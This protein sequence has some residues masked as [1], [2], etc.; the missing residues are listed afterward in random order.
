MDLCLMLPI[1]LGVGCLRFFVGIGFGLV[2][3]VDYEFGVLGLC[4]PI[5]VR[6][7]RVFEFPC[8]KR[9]CVCRYSSFVGLFGFDALCD[10]GLFLDFA[11]KLRLEVWLLHFVVVVTFFSW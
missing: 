9:C 6:G 1:D 11:L 8:R 2:G 7:R 4:C 3:F 5:C 10:F